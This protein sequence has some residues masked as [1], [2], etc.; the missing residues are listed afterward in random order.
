MSYGVRAGQ[1]SRELVDLGIMARADSLARFADRYCFQSLAVQ[2][3]LQNQGWLI[4]NN[5]EFAVAGEFACDGAPPVTA[6][7][8]NINTD[9]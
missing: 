1:R 3:R 4:V 8:M 6:I 2:I 7:T 5:N 9:L